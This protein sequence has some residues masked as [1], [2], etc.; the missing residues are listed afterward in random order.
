MPVPPADTPTLTP[1]GDLASL[2]ALPT[3][4][5][6]GLFPDFRELAADD[7]GIPAGFVSGAEFGSVCIDPGVHIAWLADECRRRGVVVGRVPKEGRI[8]HVLDARKAAAALNPSLEESVDDAE[9][10]T[11]VV[12]A[13][14]LGSLTLA[15]VKDTT[16]SPARGQSVLV[17]G[18]TSVMFSASETIL[19]R[20]ADAPAPP[21]VGADG[22]APRDESCHGMTRP[23]GA[24]TFLGGTF[25]LGNWDEEPD[26][27]VGERIIQR[28]LAVDPLL[29]NASGGVDV[30]RHMV[31]RRPWRRDGVRVEKEWIER[32]GGRGGWVV[33]NY[34]HSGWGFQGGYGCA[35]RVLELV[36]EIKRE[37]MGS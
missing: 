6:T 33:H 25:E 32:E 3:R 13:T 27:E 29:R 15:G 2:L 16:M 34:G 14:G 18:T 8:A 35:E 26:R 20:P 30:I 4:W 12:N 23:A 5:W 21:A 17:R 22:K 7:G 11:I 36:N 31:G 24:G 19:P 37:V 9:V 28:A 1:E 10:L